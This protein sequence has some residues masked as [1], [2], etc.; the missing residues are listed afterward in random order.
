MDSG[1]AVTLFRHGVTKAN[2]ERRYLGWSDP[3]ITDE[4]RDKLTGLPCEAYDLCVSSD[5]LRCRQTAAVLCSNAPY[6]ESA[7][8]RE[9]NFGKWEL[10]TYAELCHE[11][12]YRNWVD[13]PLINRPPDGESFSEMESRLNRGWQTLKSQVDEDEHR[14]ILLV[15]HGGVIRFL[16]TKLTKEKRGFWEWQILHSTGIKLY[17]E[18]L[19]WKENNRC[20]SLQAV[21]TME[22]EN[23]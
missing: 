13:N 16:L 10:A 4:A 21:P 1:V 15:T 20:T 12:E 22:S 2:L 5:L 14:N 11:P 7:A 9:M 3:P 18:T 23:G 6:V 8:F 17:W 19:D